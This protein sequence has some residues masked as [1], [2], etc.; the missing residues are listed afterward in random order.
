MFSSRTTRVPATPPERRIRS[1]PPRKFQGFFF[2]APY[3][4]Y[5]YI[6]GAERRHRVER[7]Y[8]IKFSHTLDTFLGGFT[9]FFP[10]FLGLTS[11]QKQSYNS[12]HI[13]FILAPLFHFYLFIFLVFFALHMMQRHA[14]CFSL[15]F[16]IELIFSST[17]LFFHRTV[18]KCLNFSYFA[19]SLHDGK[20]SIF[21]GQLFP[22]N[23]QKTVHGRIFT[24][25]SQNYICI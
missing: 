13:N 16:S 23:S 1:N 12:K 20:F 19:I 17:L 3:G 15:F 4:L 14:V 2:H 11:K 6:S 8:D 18:Y 24:Y 25:F 21:F 9:A 22:L 7:R 5:T 10:L